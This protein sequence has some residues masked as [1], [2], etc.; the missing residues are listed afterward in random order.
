MFRSLACLAFVSAQ[1]ISAWSPAFAQ[2]GGS[3]AGN[4]ADAAG[5]MID[6]SFD[7]PP[8]D[9]KVAVSYITLDGRAAVRIRPSEIR[10]VLAVTAEAESAE[11]C[12][13]AVGATI[14]RLKA[15]WA[16]VNVPPESV[17]VDFIAVLPR[18]KWSIE[19]REGSE[20]GIERR[21]GYHMQSNV[22]LAVPDNARAATAL[23]AAFAEG[24]TDIIAFD[25][26]SKD[27]DEAKIKVRQQA[28]K[29]ARAKADDLLAPLFD[30]KLPII[31]V[32][33]KTTVRYPD[34][35]YTSFRASYEETLTPTWRRDI[36]LIHAD[37]PRNTYYR[38]LNTDGDI[39]P[40]D[41]P[42]TPEISVISTVRLYFRSPGAE[43]PK[44]DTP[45]KQEK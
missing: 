26:W 18:Y 15:A 13:Q 41:L 5:Q 6:R 32:Q 7:P 20:V 39:Q 30:G 10:I 34:A 29:A 17:F 36:A 27:L 4:E 21:S 24:V 16:K 2:F 25:Y 22:H 44:K 28:V 14:D 38:G 1:F 43:A 40:R 42:M 8:L 3:R 37:R 9:P 31:N 12:Q 33:E 23:S 45:V 19:Q 35:M 11:K